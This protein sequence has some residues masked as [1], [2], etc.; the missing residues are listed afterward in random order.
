MFALNAVFRQ[1]GPQFV[2]TA[3]KAVRKVLEEKQA[4][5]NVLVLRGI[6]LPAKGIGGLPESVGVVQ[7]AGC[8][9]VIRDESSALLPFFKSHSKPP[10]RFREAN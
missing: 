8:Y 5:N 7:V 1:F 2:A 3:F 9:V 6:D 10:G 4:Q